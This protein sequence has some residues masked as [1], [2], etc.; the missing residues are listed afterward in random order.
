LNLNNYTYKGAK[1]IAEH[2]KEKLQ[3]QKYSHEDPYEG[4]ASTK[5]KNPRIY[6]GKL[7]GVS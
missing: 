3:K 4:R 5:I 1:I 7:N 2:A 6:I